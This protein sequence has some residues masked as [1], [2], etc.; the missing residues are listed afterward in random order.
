MYLASN[1]WAKTTA[2]W[3]EKHLIFQICC[4]LYYRFDSNQNKTSQQIK[5]NFIHWLQV[6][7]DIK[8]WCTEWLLANPWLIRL[9]LFCKTF[10]TYRDNKTAVLCLIYTL[11]KTI[12][13][14]ATDA[15]IKS[16]NGI[17]HFNLGYQERSISQLT[18]AIHPDNK[19]HGANM[20]PTWVLSA[21][22]GPHV[23][24]HEPCYRGCIS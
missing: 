10:R 4:V 7:K 8:Y 12:V 6:I 20:G 17:H 13:S 11:L 22:D 15:L 1:D 2:R 19:V 24:P 5:Y 16:G 14:I 21:P 18:V 23:R 3:Y 9:S